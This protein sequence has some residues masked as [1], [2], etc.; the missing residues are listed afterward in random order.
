[1]LSWASKRL[2]SSELRSSDQPLQCSGFWDVTISCTIE[3]FWFPQIGRTYSHIYQGHE[4]TQQ[5]CAG[6]EKAG[7]CSSSPSWSDPVQAP[8]AVWGAPVWGAPPFQTGDGQRVLHKVSGC[9]GLAA[10]DSRAAARGRALRSPAPSL[11]DVCQR[12]A[13]HRAAMPGNGF[14]SQHLPSSL[15]C[16]LVFLLA[17]WQG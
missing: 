17:D 2:V 10:A 14:G 12:T 9:L 4:K 1:M 13:S 16:H 7:T 5:I 6:I 8:G 15:W 3:L 11:R